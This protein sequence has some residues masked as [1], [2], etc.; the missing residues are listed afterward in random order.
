LAHAIPRRPR[1]LSLVCI[2]AFAPVGVA[3]QSKPWGQTGESTA[4]PQARFLVSKPGDTL[5]RLVAVARPTP[6]PD[7]SESGSGWASGIL[8]RQRL[9]EREHPQSAAGRRTRHV[10][11]AVERHRALTALLVPGSDHRAEKPLPS[12]HRKHLVLV[13]SGI[14]GSFLQALLSGGVPESVAHDLIRVLGHELDLQRELRPGDNF[15]VLF[16]RYR[17]DTGGFLRDGKVLH[18]SFRVS[19]RDLS[20]WRHET[21]RGPEWFDGEGRSLRRG[22]LRTPL[23]GARITSGFGMRQHPV[24]GFTR[25]HQGVDFAAPTGTPVVAA[26]DG[27]VTA[28]GPRSA[29]GRTV[30]LSH[31]GGTETLYAHLSS[32]APGLAPGQQVR[33]GQMIGRVGSTGMSSGPHLHYEISQGGRPVDP[34]TV[35]S[36]VTTRLTG[37]ELAGFQGTQRQV[38]AWLSRMEPMQEL[39]MAD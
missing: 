11:V 20:I 5:S 1:A 4:L 34:A 38:Q 23:D 8:D 17:A 9:L 6:R 26:A 16:E 32:F 35:R 39:A 2:L 28:I 18:A 33:Q 30:T 27:T 25:M 15:S 22:F 12:D 31:S 7:I 19:G 21:A 24:L 37:P 10:P 13:R 29:Y 14:Q 3:A 36:G